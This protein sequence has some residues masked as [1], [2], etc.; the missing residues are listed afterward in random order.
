[1]APHARFYR[2][3]FP[4]FSLRFPFLSTTARQAQ[5]GQSV[6]HFS[7]ATEV[8]CTAR[9]GSKQ[10]HTEWHRVVAFGK[11]ADNC[12]RLLSEGRQVYIEG[13]LITRQLL[14]ERRER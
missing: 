11:L 14:S 10:E 5:F 1:M 7:V 2:T 4:L 6:A 12:H 3:Q 13:R 9:D 8:L